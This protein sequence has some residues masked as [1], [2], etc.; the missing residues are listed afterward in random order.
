MVTKKF[1]AASSQALSGS[2]YRVHVTAIDDSGN[3]GFATVQIAVLP[4]QPRSGSAK[5]AKHK[6]A[7]V[8]KPK[9]K[10]S[11]KVVTR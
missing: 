3:A 11:K 2:P 7:T 1:P 10:T 9:Q 8:P 6:A 4:T 5:D